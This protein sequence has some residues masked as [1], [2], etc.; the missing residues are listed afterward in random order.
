[1]SRPRRQAGSH[2][3]PRSTSHRDRTRRR[4]V[5][6]AVAPAS[7]GRPSERCPWP[8]SCSPRA[9]RVRWAALADG[10][11]AGAGSRSRA[12]PRCDAGGRTLAPLAARHRAG[13]LWGLVRVVG[14]LA[15]IDRVRSVTAQAVG[16]ASRRQR[17]LP[18]DRRGAARDA[19]RRSVRP[20]SGHRPGVVPDRHDRGAARCRT[21]RPSTSCRARSSDCRRSCSPSFGAVATHA[22]FGAPISAARLAWPVL[23]ARLG[24]RSRASYTALCAIA[25]DAARGVA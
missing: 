25:P 11:V 15:L 6:G 16:T 10:P 4:T 5:V 13:W 22:T 2:E 23:G 19:D 1:M 21:S 8:P 20:P 18:L 7:S 9:R 24:C 17:D 14:G 12:R 3:H